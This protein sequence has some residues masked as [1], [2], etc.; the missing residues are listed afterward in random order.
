M[1]LEVYWGSGSPYAWRVLL[2]LEVKQVPYASRLIEFSKKQHKSPEFL[3]L[4]PRGKVPVLK[5][6]GFSLSESLA[7]VAYLDRK[8]PEPP[9]FGRSA[10]ETGLIWKAISEALHYLEPPAGR[11]IVPVF[12][13]KA[14]EAAADIA[15]A[16]PALHDELRRLNEAL[17]GQDWLVGA[18]L[19]AADIAV[20]PFIEILLRV[21]GK[22]IAQPLD[23]GLL[24]LSRQYGAMARW[25]ER[26]RTL[27]GYERTYPPHWRAAA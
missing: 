21:A 26:I 20:Y 23:L 2:A 4:N 15:A 16:K 25:C 5:D 19:T 13:N 11:I 10:A 9:L 1:S 14:A 6:D 22:D 27:P 7:I 8:F 12:S 18:S 24:P 17:A 3:A